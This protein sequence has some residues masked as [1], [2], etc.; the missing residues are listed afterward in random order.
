MDGRD[1]HGRQESTDG[2]YHRGD[3]QIVQSA[4]RSNIERRSDE[5]KRLISM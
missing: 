3:N 2:M 1:F 4:Q 5:L